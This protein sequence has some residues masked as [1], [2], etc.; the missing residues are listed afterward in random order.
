MKPRS[1]DFSTQDSL[2]STVEIRLASSDDLS[3]TNLIID[4]ATARWG[5][6]ER[7][8]RLS[9]SALHYTT[10]DLQSMQ[11]IVAS[12]V[13]SESIAVAAWEPADAKD[14]PNGMHATILHG[15][16]VDASV[17]RTGIGRQ[18][19]EVVCSC[20]TRQ[21]YAAIAVRAWRESEAFFLRLGFKRFGQNEPIDV[22]PNRLWRRL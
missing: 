8:Q 1:L 16:Y 2:N 22:F 20:A 18:L 7:V 19:V 12:G 3:E 9:R 4:R 21:G 11:V 10:T 13:E 6:S 14:T 15:I 5:L 17:Q